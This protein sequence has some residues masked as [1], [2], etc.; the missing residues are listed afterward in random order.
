LDE[1]I[2]TYGSAEEARKWVSTPELSAHVTGD[3]VDVGATDAA[4]WFSQF[5]N[6]YGLCQTY[7]NEIWHYEL[8]VDPGGQCPEPAADASAT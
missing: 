5:G 3:A 6:L 1:A 7:A 8:L 4:Y 2:T